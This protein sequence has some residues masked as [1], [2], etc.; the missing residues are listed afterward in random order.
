MVMGTPAPET[1]R[2]RDEVGRGKGKCG[3]ATILLPPHLSQGHEW[4]WAL[5]P[6]PQACLKIS[7]QK[8]RKLFH[9][10][11]TIKWNRMKQSATKWTETSQNNTNLN[12]KISFPLMK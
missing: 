10:V 7:V 8:K 1:R 9:E 2:L 5:Q 6:Q 4:G 3:K 12:L 11:E